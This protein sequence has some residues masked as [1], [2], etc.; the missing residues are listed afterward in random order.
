MIDP[1]ITDANTPVA[2]EPQTDLLRTPVLAQRHLDQYPGFVPYPWSDLVLASIHGKSVGLGGSITPKT[3][4]SSALTA[5]CGFV[6]IYNPGNLGRVMTCFHQGMNL[7]SLLLGKLRVASHVYA[8]CLAVRDK[9]V[10]LLELAFLASG[11]V[12][13]RS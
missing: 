8:S 10:M 3:P 5:D 12:A 4:V 11:G 7:V 9:L 1:F 6:N 13:L 2:P